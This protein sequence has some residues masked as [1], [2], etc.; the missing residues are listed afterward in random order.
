L[1]SF[2][3]NW[4]WIYSL[5]SGVAMVFY[6][7][8]LLHLARLLN[9]ELVKLSPQVIAMGAISSALFYCILRWPV[10]S[11]KSPYLFAA[12]Y[13]LLLSGGAYVVQ[14]FHY[15]QIPWQWSGVWT[16]L[17]MITI[18]AGVF[19]SPQSWM[20]K[21]GFGLR[22][23]YLVKPLVVA[24]CWTVWALMPLIFLQPLELFGMMLI[25][26]LFVFALVLITDIIDQNAD[27]STTKTIVTQWGVTKTLVLIV[28]LSV[29]SEVLIWKVFGGLLP[30]GCILLASALPLLSLTL[31]K[32][33]LSSLL[34][35]GALLILYFLIQ[36][37][38]G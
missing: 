28:V 15:A 4:W 11:K 37:L 2:K 5:V 26:L 32:K 9:P 17:L 18:I 27:Q 29:F 33:Y 10:Q 6:I 24:W 23:Y 19:Y 34:V 1:E 14:S 36:G 3:K 20:T 38:D 22:R 31:R 12:F 13:G 25:S 35:D 7:S 30:S 16:G 8:A 21:W